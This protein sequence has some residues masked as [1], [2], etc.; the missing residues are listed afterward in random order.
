MLK[1]Q[2]KVQNL[3]LQNN[4]RFIN[5]YL[6]LEELMEHLQRTDIYLLPKIQIKR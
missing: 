6:S 1:T 4:V 3:N 2:V 5:R